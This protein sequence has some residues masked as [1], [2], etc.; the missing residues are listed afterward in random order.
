MHVSRAII[1][2]T[3]IM[4]PAIIAEI[5]KRRM[6]RCCLAAW[7]G[8]TNKPAILKS[9]SPRLPSSPV[10]DPPPPFSEGVSSLT[11]QSPSSVAT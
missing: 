11:L 9:E 8:Q 10:V 3:K 6:T 4:T 7:T 5:K 2:M 1:R